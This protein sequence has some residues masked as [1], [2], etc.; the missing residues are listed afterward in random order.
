[1]LNERRDALCPAAKRGS[2]IR[3]PLIS[4]KN[5]YVKTVIR[6]K[7]NERFGLKV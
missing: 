1:M 7:T 6:K 3:L 5:G 4:V 2:A